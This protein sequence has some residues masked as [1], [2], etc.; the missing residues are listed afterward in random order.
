VSQAKHIKP[1]SSA[2]L[3]LLIGAV[4]GAIFMIS[5]GDNWHLAPDASID[6]LDIIDAVSPA[7]DCPAAE[8]PLAGRFVV[9][10]SDLDLEGH[11]F[12][13]QD[14]PCPLGTQG[15]SGSC[16]TV[17]A[18]PI[19]DVSLGESGFHTVPGGWSCTAHNNEATPVRIRVY[20]LCLKPAP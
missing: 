10:S 5:C 3:M 8:P 1:A 12:S 14:A 17:P 11:W 4:A 18:S 9:V 20:A 6:A 13:S 19:R 16:A 15:I 7:C 2:I